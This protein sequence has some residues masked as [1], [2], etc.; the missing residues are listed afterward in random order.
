MVCK[1]RDDDLGGSVEEGEEE[2]NWKIL[3]WFKLD[4]LPLL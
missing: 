4:I 2:H 3:S 1:G